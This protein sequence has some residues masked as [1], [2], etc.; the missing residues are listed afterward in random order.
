MAVI[1]QTFART[2]ADYLVFVTQNQQEADLWVSVSPIMSGS[3]ED[4]IWFFTPNENQASSV[5]FLSSRAE[6]VCIVFFVNEPTAAGWRN[7]KKQTYLR[8]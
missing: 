3:G 5:I 7:K 6:A 1:Y 2:E 8:F 4:S